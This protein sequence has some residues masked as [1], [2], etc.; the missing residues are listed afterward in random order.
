MMRKRLYS[1][2]NSAIYFL[3]RQRDSLL[4]FKEKADNKLK[5]THLNRVG[6]DIDL[7][8]DKLKEIETHIDSLYWGIQEPSVFNI[9]L[10]G[11]FGTGKSTIISQLIKQKKL[12]NYQI[13]S[14]GKFGEDLEKEPKERI[15]YSILEQLIFAVK[16]KDVPDSKINRIIQTRWIGWRSIGIILFIY[17]IIF[18]FFDQVNNQIPSISTRLNFDIIKWFWFI[19]FVLGLFFLIKKIYRSILDYRV[20]KISL[21]DIEISDSRNSSNSS[22]PLLNQYYD[23]ILYYFVRTKKRI[24]FI[25]DLDRFE[26]SRFIYN[27]LREI[28]TLLN[29]SSEFKNDKITFVYAIKNNFIGDATQTNK[30][31]E[32]VIPVLPFISFQTSKEIFLEELKNFS[33]FKTKNTKVPKEI[34]DLIVLI[35]SFIV[36]VRTIY[37]IVN[38]FKITW[39]NFNIQKKEFK[40]EELLAFSI[41]KTILNDDYDLLLRR[42]GVLFNLFQNKSLIQKEKTREYNNKIEVCG[43]KIKKI[44]AEFP[45]SLEKLRKLFLGELSRKLNRS[46]YLKSLTFEELL[47]EET[48]EIYYK[49]SIVIRNNH[50]TSIKEIKGF[51]ELEDDLGFKYLERK[52]IILNKGDKE[53]EKIKQ[54]QQEID[55]VVSKSLEELLEH[56]ISNY[57]KSVLLTSDLDIEFETKESLIEILNTDESVSVKKR[58]AI[59]SL[60]SNPD[61]KNKIKSLL[62][63]NAQKVLQLLILDG[64]INEGYIKLLSYSYDVYLDSDTDI[65][66]QRI[67]R[68]EIP[69]KDYLLKVDQVKKL[70]RELRPMYFSKPAIL[71]FNIVHELLLKTENNY[72]KFNLFIGQFEKN[73]IHLESVFVGIFH[74]E[75]FDERQRF[76]FAK[77][78]LKANYFW[79]QL[80]DINDSETQNNILSFIINRYD[81][82]KNELSDVDFEGFKIKLTDFIEED[83]SVLN[84]VDGLDILKELDYK[85]KKT[86]L[87][88]SHIKNIIFDKKLFE[89]NESNLKDCLD[90]NS[91]DNELNVGNISNLYSAYEDIWGL[92]A[93]SADLKTIIDII[94][95]IEDPVIEKSDNALELVLNVEENLDLD[96]KKSYIRKVDFKINDIS[97]VNDKEL[98]KFLVKFKR[99]KPKWNNVQQYSAENDLD[100]SLIEYINDFSKELKFDEYDFIEKTENQNLLKKILKNDEIRDKEIFDNSFICIDNINVL[101]N[102]QDLIGYFLD[103]D[104]I[105]INRVNFDFLSEENKLKI[106]DGNFD[107][108]SNSEEVSHIEKLNITFEDIK[109]L[110][111]R[112]INEKAKILLTEYLIQHDLQNID[113]AYNEKFTELFVRSLFKINSEMLTYQVV[114]HILLSES[115]DLNSRI[116]LAIFYLKQENIKEPMISDVLYYL[117]NEYKALSDGARTHFENNDLNKLLL[118]YLYKLNYIVEPKLISNETKISVRK[119]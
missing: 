31:F 77:A 103:Q 99:I 26:H 80:Q 86:H 105:E 27:K 29:H 24:L 67:I 9:A 108:E 48:F 41:Y 5:L 65:Y 43:E 94:V 44:E 106:I 75:E 15:E 55:N 83:E 81:K 8:E 97:E 107:Y 118:E 39:K 13:I 45:K 36:D 100:D 6:E 116:E 104:F 87:L 46:Q 3:E 110:Y 35:S 4:I 25:E 30:F 113:L 10:S 19:I 20:S 84:K 7:P 76:L 72:T 16:A 52:N 49:K 70:I 114:E 112:V 11:G 69:D 78:L 101:E 28:N 32:L 57:W 85:I 90:H 98:W 95:S 117:G 47:D 88:E 92:D 1:L 93:L 64:Y 96:Q 14:L 38:D 2:I 74:K 89:V 56:D 66:Y 115:I 59:D 60:S 111:H 22:V 21:S 63:N 53:R 37:S 102:Q 71:N 73:S 12:S 33:G 79:I 62:I 51:Q 54:F 58:K 18:L 34:V 23:E 17:S 119:L 68:S 50:N 42:K 61:Y 109:D 91:F 82:I 40:L